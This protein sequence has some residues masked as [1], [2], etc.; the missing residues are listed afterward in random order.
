M[1]FLV[2][3]Y[4]LEEIDKKIGDNFWSPVDV[5]KVNDWILRAAAFKGEFKWHFHNHDELFYIYKGKIT[6]DT[7][8]GPIE[9]NEG[10]GTVIPKGMQHKPRADER[11][12]VLML[13]P[14]D[15]E[16]TGD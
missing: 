15:A 1:K 4:N 5:A 8:S 9:L 11:A 7:E 14:A 2:E 16:L 6:I 12:I 13:D 3:K 10:E